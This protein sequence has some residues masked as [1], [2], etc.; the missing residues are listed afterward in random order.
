MVEGNVHVDYRPR[1]YRA[2]SKSLETLNPLNATYDETILQQ[3]RCGLHD[4][5][6]LTPDVRPLWRDRERETR[7]TV[8]E[9]ERLAS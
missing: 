3:E 2:S 1:R 9:L 6:E 8:L 7:E 5:S 4:T